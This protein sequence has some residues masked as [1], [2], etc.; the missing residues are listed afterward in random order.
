V[1]SRRQETNDIY[2]A[3][4]PLTSDLSPPD[5]TKNL[6]LPISL[7]KGTRT[8][9]S[10]YLIANLLSYDYLSST[11]R[12]MSACLDSITVPKIMKNALNHPKWYDAILGKIHALEDNHTWG[13]DGFTQQKKLVGCKSMFTTKVNPYGSMARHKA[14]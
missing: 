12:S 6:D 1:F 11:S 4:V 5:P 14:K 8:C 7:R 3:I 10:T 13:F 9:K 2:L